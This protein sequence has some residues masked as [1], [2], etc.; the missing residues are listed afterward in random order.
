MDK[1]KLNNGDI[2]EFN[3][4]SETFKSD[5]VLFRVYIHGEITPKFLNQIDIYAKLP[6]SGEVELKPVII[7]NIKPFKPQLIYVPPEDP[8]RWDD[9]PSVK[10]KVVFILVHGINPEEI[11]DRKPDIY[12]IWQTP[13]K[14]HIWDT[15]HNMIYKHIENS[16]ILHY[17]YPSAIERL[18]YNAQALRDKL[19]K[20]NIEKAKKVI[21]IGHS[22]GGLVIRQML[23]ESEWLRDITTNVF[24]LNTPHRGSPLASLMFTPHEF[25]DYMESKGDEAIKKARRIR[26]AVALTYHSGG[27]VMSQGYLDLRWDHLDKLERFPLMLSE[28]IYN[29]NLND[30]FNRYTFTTSSIPKYHLGLSILKLTDKMYHEPKDHIGLIMMQKLMESM[31]ELLQTGIWQEGDGLVPISSQIPVKYMENGLNFNI[32]GPFSGDHID[33]FTRPFIWE[34]ILK[35]I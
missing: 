28:E 30:K 5:I 25:W 7:G 18:T 17:I 35:L 12:D 13:Y 23:I 32:L 24:T 3:G 29:L 19:L 22:M 4:Y 9:I 26:Q 34:K 21:F 11:L 10:D 31:G 14:Y 6:L 15:A 2:V 8:H 33:I 27:A 1:I 16:V 20:T